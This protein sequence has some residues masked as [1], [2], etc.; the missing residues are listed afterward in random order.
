MTMFPMGLL[1]VDAVLLSVKTGK[2]AAKAVNS[3]RDTYDTYIKPTVDRMN[4]LRPPLIRVTRQDDKEAQDG[5]LQT[6]FAFDHVEII[7]YDAENGEI[8]A[9]REKEILATLALEEELSKK[10]QEGPAAK[11]T[12]TKEV[13]Q[14]TAPPEA[15]VTK[16]GTKTQ[17]HVELAI[18]DRNVRLGEID[19]SDWSRHDFHITITREDGQPLK[20][21]ERDGVLNTLKRLTKVSNDPSLNPNDPA[22]KIAPTT[23]WG[24]IGDAVKSWWTGSVVRQSV[25]ADG[26]RE[27]HHT[28]EAYVNGLLEVAADR[29]KKDDESILEN[30]YA[31]EEQL[32]KNELRATQHSQKIF[33]K[34]L[35]D[36]ISERRKHRLI[37][38]GAIIGGALLAT[39]IVA[40]AIF[41]PA[42]GIPLVT[43]I[44]GGVV[45]S[46][47]E[48]VIFGGLTFI[49]VIVL[50]WG[51]AKAYVEYRTESIAHDRKR[52]EDL[53]T[54]EKDL[55][56][57]LKNLQEEK[58]AATNTLK[59]VKALENSQAKTFDLSNA[60]I[61]NIGV[62]L[63]CERLSSVVGLQNC[64]HLLLSS[65]GITKTG[66]FALAK[67]LK[68][69]QPPQFN[70]R[71]IDLSGNSI[72]VDGIAAIQEALSTNFMVTT[73]R[74][75]RTNVP[76]EVRDA[77]DRWLLINRYIQ[78]ISPKMDETEERMQMLFPNGMDQLEAAAKAKIQNNF[79][80]TVLPTSPGSPLL[81]EINAITEQNKLFAQFHAQQPLTA[82]VYTKAF[83]INSRRYNNF[84]A[85][86]PEAKQRQAKE[87]ISQ[88]ISALKD[89]GLEKCIQLLG[90]IVPDSKDKESK[91]R[92]LAN[93]LANLKG[94]D[95]SPIVHRTLQDI[96]IDCLGNHTYEE[97]KQSITKKQLEL[98]KTDIDKDYTPEQREDANKAFVLALADSAD[99][100][101][102]AS[103]KL[104]LQTIVTSHP[105]PSAKDDLQD[106]LMRAL[107]EF[108]DIYKVIPENEFASVFSEINLDKFIELVIADV[109]NSAKTK[110]QQVTCTQLSKLDESHRRALLEACFK[111]ANRYPNE[112]DAAKKAALVSKIIG[113]ASI[114]DLD[115]PTM[116]NIR[117]YIL[118]YSFTT[119]Y[120]SPDNYEKLKQKLVDERKVSK[121]A[122]AG[123]KTTILDGLLQ[124]D[125][126]EELEIKYP[127]LKAPF[128]KPSEKQLKDLEAD[129]NKVPPKDF[130][131]LRSEFPGVTDKG[132][133]ACINRFSNRNKLY[134]AISD[135]ATSD[136][137]LEKFV[138]TYSAMASDA[139]RQECLE[140][141]I[142]MAPGNTAALLELVKNEV[143]KKP[144]DFK[145][146]K[147]LSP[148]QRTDL[149]EKCLADDYALH[150]SGIATL[151]SRLTEIATAAGPVV[152]DYVWHIFDWTVSSRWE[153]EEYIKQLKTLRDGNP[154]AGLDGIIQAG[155]QE[156]LIARFGCLNNTGD[157]FEGLRRE[158]D[159]NYD[160][161]KFIFSPE[162]IPTKDVK[163]YIESI[164]HRNLALQ[165]IKRGNL[166]AFTQ[167]YAA[168]D[169]WHLAD[170]A[171]STPFS[172]L[173]PTILEII[174]PNLGDSKKVGWGLMGATRDS[175]ETTLNCSELIKL[176]RSHRIALLTQGFTS[177]ETKEHALKKAIL[178]SNML[179]LLLKY[180]IHAK[181]KL[182]KDIAY[183]IYWALSPKNNFNLAMLQ[184]G[185]EEIAGKIDSDG[186]SD[187]PKNLRKTIREALTPESDVVLTM[188]SA[189]M[190]QPAP[191][192]SKVETESIEQALGS[193]LLP[194]AKV[195]GKPKS[196]TK[197]PTA[198]VD[199]KQGST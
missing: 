146:L 195:P 2:Y 3:V 154:S 175:Y 98:A 177:T 35:A 52:L 5:T 180:E 169:A 135:Y 31:A 150:A 111:N 105:T 62:K 15:P 32:R 13:Q 107:S 88:K 99:Y 28:E 76:P 179:D 103:R 49:G 11:P 6:V 44:I 90:T 92:L 94:K 19:Y 173:E 41:I 121:A 187:A 145:E 158:L 155:L 93:I 50:A 168:I 23:G 4:G 80:V 198:T 46:A 37:V 163:T 79:S 156:D 22:T 84:I 126:R 117:E 43:S 144:Y 29:A 129:L 127:F 140:D 104:R 53:M 171:F 59:I 125:L 172:E 10:K 193:A 128:G 21:E 199:A 131:D 192:P 164:C 34:D 170:E 152:P 95:V 63:I 123:A 7:D 109:Y 26:G 17:Y 18:D 48:K 39:G 130:L 66:A 189:L 12:V 36:R 194:P 142:A 86:L 97:F 91:I 56:E 185:L 65:N 157:G 122:G 124:A 45:T 151:V 70:V 139:E 149:L 33:I 161:T 89:L 30:F 190:E 110:G 27:S 176:D 167:E 77:I 160:L 118:Y 148:A 82:E 51:S 73:L 166:N 71:E 68:Q 20:P 54:I 38:A 72:E 101:S 133:M 147:R 67:A 181:D 42:I 9:T 183:E 78:G 106:A 16:P 61:G 178:V 134:D 40:L 162:K 58:N 116:V 184:Q 83:G 25:I 136:K 24:G 87:I 108:I 119:I 115:D 182:I 81:D 174:G 60:N 74:Y 96:F 153:F 186:Y 165:A 8:E 197:A 112:K 143:G 114:F 14:P 196:P 69:A 100:N 132:V 191:I 57:G 137:K 120:G 141:F 47:L 85:T 55:T 64:E 138:D 113:T 188:Q 1:A 75:D 159:Q 102:P